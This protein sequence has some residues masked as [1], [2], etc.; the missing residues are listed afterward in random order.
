MDDQKAIEQLNLQL[1]NHIHHEVEHAL[2]SPASINRTVGE[3]MRH[4]GSILELNSAAYLP[5]RRE[6]IL[7]PPI[8]MRPDSREAVLLLARTISSENAFMVLSNCK[9]VED[10]RAFDLVAYKP[11]TFALN[12]TRFIKLPTE[13]GNEIIRQLNELL[14][15]DGTTLLQAVIAKDYFD[16]EE[17][18]PEDG[19]FSSDVQPSSEPPAPKITP[20]VSTGG[21]PPVIED[22]LL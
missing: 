21:L 2:E 15:T 3:A 19:L 22:H 8:Q 13:V 6:E 14:K 20:S 18:N 9:T 11:D 16:I 10:K 7:V 12:K 1:L 4:I 5:I 17:K